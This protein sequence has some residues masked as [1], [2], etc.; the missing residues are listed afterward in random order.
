MSQVSKIDH[1]LHYDAAA[2]V[3]TTAAPV[4]EKPTAAR[5]WTHRGLLVGFFLFLVSVPV[6]Q[7]VSDLSRHRLPEPLHVFRRV[8]T[9]ENIQRYEASL[10]RTAVVGQ[11]L[12]PYVQSAFTR[13]AQRGNQKVVVGPGHWLFFRESVDHVVKPGFMRLLEE[14]GTAAGGDPL[15]AILAFDESLRAHGVR[16]V[17]LPAPGKEVIHP[18]HLVRGYASA[19]RPLDNPDTSTFFTALRQRGVAVFDPTEILWEAK[20]HTTEPLYL[21]Y[22]S[23]WSPIGMQLVARGLAR[24]LREHAGVADVRPVSYRVEKM[25]VR[26]WGDLYGMLDLL[27]ERGGLPPTHV[28]VQ[29]VVRATDGR[30]AVPDDRSPVLLMGDSFTVIYSDGDLGWGESAGL[31]EHLA[32]AL[33]SGVDVFA[34]RGIGVNTVPSRLANQPELLNGKQ[35]V[36]WQ[37]AARYLT[38]KEGKWK[39]IRVPAPKRLA[40]R[41]PAP[42]D[43]TSYRADTKIDEPGQRARFMKG[44]ARVG[45]K[46]P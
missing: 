3:A 24:Y 27:P 39:P 23:H 40:T 36:I 21:P 45:S 30:P 35:V 43:D 1:A 16:L 19:D 41:L 14:K 32:L 13:V 11:W 4:A 42:A 26:N 8:P 2:V 25:A 37:F 38:L 44:S 5:Y 34:R 20:K 31:A 10:D 6:A 9:G 28:E 46:S 22:D 17:I 18:E 12:R 33:G 7:I 29:K 15:S